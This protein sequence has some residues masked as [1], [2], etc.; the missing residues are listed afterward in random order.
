MRTRTDLLLGFGVALSLAGSGD[1]FAGTV[2]GRYTPSFS[3]NVGLTYTDWDIGP[4]NNTT[5]FTFNW[6][7]SDL[8]P[9]PGVDTTLPEQF[10]SYC[11]D[12]NQE[13]SG[14]QTHT[15]EV[16][17]LT[18]KG[19]SATQILLLSRLWGAFQALVNSPDTSAAFQTSVYEIIYDGNGT[20]NLNAGDLIMQTP[21]SAKA[22]ATSWLAQV[23]D[24]NTPLPT[25]PLAALTNPTLQDQLVVIPSPGAAVLFVAAGGVLAARRRRA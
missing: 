13:V 25:V 12:L 10:V 23:A 3:R 1:A 15:Y 9:G 22:I 17:T 6:R 16:V 21:D 20:I 18:S 8:P 4:S 14:N 2:T 24:L 11:I 7:R 19:F 5:T